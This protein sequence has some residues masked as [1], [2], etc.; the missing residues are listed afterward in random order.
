MTQET[1]KNAVNE[2]AQAAETAKKSGK[3]AFEHA[4]ATAANAYEQMNA[5]ASETLRKG[6]ERSVGVMGEMGE[7]SKKNMEAV[8]ESTK[9]TTKAM[10]DIGTRYADFSRGTFERGMEAAKSMT[11]AQSVQE[12]MEMQAGYAK[13]FMETYLEEVNALTGRF[14]SMVKDASAPINAQAGQVVSTL[15]A[16]A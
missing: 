9:I 1:I 5:N 7:L 6:Y 15:Q 8:A 11:S 14:A 16:R 12:A 3:A 4:N 2:A 10:E 13:S